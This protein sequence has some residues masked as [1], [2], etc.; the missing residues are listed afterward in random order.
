MAIFFSKKNAVSATDFLNPDPLIFS[1]AK[2]MSVLLFFLVG[3]LLSCVA[4]MP[5][6]KKAGV[7][8]KKA[9]IPGVNF[10]EWCRLIGRKP[11]HALWLLFPIANIFVWCAMAVDLVRSFGKHGFWDETLAVIFSPLAFWKTDRSGAKYEGPVL[12]AERKFH[13]DLTAAAGDKRATEKIMAATPFKKSAIRE[14]TEAIV[15]AVFAA[16]FIRMFL[17]EA[18][19]IPTSSM[20]GSLRVGD[21]LFVSKAHY[22]VRMPTTVLQFPLIHNR[23]PMVDKESYSTAWSLDYTRLPALEA[24]DR[25]EPIVF[26]FPEGDS[27]YVTPNRTFSMLDMRGLEMTGTPAAKSQAAFMKHYGLTT[28]PLDKRDHYIK[29][30]VAIAGDSLQVKDGQLFVN[31]QKAQNPTEMQYNYHV[32][33]PK[34]Q[35]LSAKFLEDIDV[36]MNDCAEYRDTLGWITLNQAQVQKVEATG[37]RL[38]RAN[39]QPP[40]PYYMF[41]KDPKNFPGQ[42]MDNFGPIWVPKKG[43]TVKLTDSTLAPYHR[44][45]TIYEGNKLEVRSGKIFINGA[46]TDSYTFKQ[47]YFWAMGDNRHQSED[48]RVWGYVPEDHIVGKPLFVWFSVRGPETYAT[49]SGHG[50]LSRIRWNRIF[51]GATKP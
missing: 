37:A 47:N 14:W 1:K 2:T 6:F 44:V 40:H 5:L 8:P 42:T 15:F 18:F 25:G 33:M 3:Y 38:R 30:C 46:E 23:L 35:T 11:S 22:G 31:G 16:A 28:R 4:L 17:I 51:S 50:L 29:R 7:D 36:N 12:E 43:A 34:G 21:F 13:A 26:N 10:V 32:F 19:V 41:P 20:E 9:L 49:K 24:I 27:V 45:I 39:P 48:S